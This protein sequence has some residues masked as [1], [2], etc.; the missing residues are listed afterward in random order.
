[1]TNNE[2]KAKLTSLIEMRPPD[3]LTP[4]IY[5][6]YVARRK[7]YSA[8][9]NMRLSLSELFKGIPDSEYT[10]DRAW[11]CWAIHASPKLLV[12]KYLAGEF[13]SDPSSG[14]DPKMFSN[15]F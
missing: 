13:I 7:E 5:Q 1:M 8:E 11:K 6:D 4:E 15:K 10:Y 12:D 2:R 9:F 3:W 14:Q